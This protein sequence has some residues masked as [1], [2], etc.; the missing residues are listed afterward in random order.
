MSLRSRKG[1]PVAALVLVIAAWSAARMILW[2]TPFAREGLSPIAQSLAQTSPAPEARPGLPANSVVAAGQPEGQGRRAAD[3][4]GSASTIVQVAPITA[5]LPME[6]VSPAQP[7]FDGARVAGGQQMLWMAA[8]AQLPMPSGLSMHMPVPPV[9][10]A[11][12]PGSTSSQRRWSADGWLAWRSGGTGYNLPGSGLPG[13]R[14]PIGTYGASQYGAVLRYRL[15]RSSRLRPTIYLRGTGSVDRPRYQELAA[16]VSARP[17]GAVPVAALAEV[18]ATRSFGET[19]VRPALALVSELPP[20]PLPLAA[21]GEA[22]LQAGYVGGKG[23]TMFVDGQLKIDRALTG[24]GKFELRAG[25]GAWGGAQEG[26]RR[27]DIGPTASIG[28]SNGP[29]ATRL[30]ADW[31]FRVAGRAAP[32]SGPAITLSAG[33]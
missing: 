13:A 2:E 8:M 33:F 10:L 14:L 21:R 20:I 23:S 6:Q 22:Y 7:I 18:R 15:D 4:S 11:S 16:G 29:A 25:A 26:A 19:R 28:L 3:P 24:P 9:G 27:L 1:Q 5:P 30:S 17:L 32:G 12:K 31:R